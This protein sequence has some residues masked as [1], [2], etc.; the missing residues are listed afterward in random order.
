MRQ[1]EKYEDFLKLYKF[2]IYKQW[3]Y[4]EYSQDEF[5]EGERQ[6]FREWCK[7]NNVLE[8]EKF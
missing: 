4:D 8:Y 1:S 6:N 3:N 7:K 5:R 2:K